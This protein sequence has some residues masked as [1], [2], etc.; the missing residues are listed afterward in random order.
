[1]ISPKVNVPLNYRVRAKSESE[2]IVLK[3]GSTC[4]CF[5]KLRTAF[6]VSLSDGFVS[7]HG[8]ILYV[9]LRG[10]TYNHR[11]TILYANAHPIHNS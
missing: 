10:T 9:G 1:M 6:G 7:T 2:R 3:E 4:F 11:R 5:Y 8:W